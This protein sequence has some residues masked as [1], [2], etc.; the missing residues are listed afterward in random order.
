MQA[1]SKIS[2]KTFCIGRHVFQRLVYP[3]RLALGCTVFWC[4][5]YFRL[6]VHTHF[7]LF[8]VPVNFLSKVSSFGKIV[9]KWSSDPYLKH[10]FGFR[11]LCPVCLLL[12]LH[13]LKGYFVLYLSF[14]CCLNHFSVG[15]EPPQWLRLDWESFYFLYLLLNFQSSSNK[16]ARQIKIIFYQHFFILLSYD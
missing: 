12:E 10:I 7:M 3:L 8:C 16:F 5:V 9:M 15:C 11:P 14:L 13:E 1:V 4:L 6:S 2:S